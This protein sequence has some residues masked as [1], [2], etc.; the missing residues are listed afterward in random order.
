MC[1]HVLAIAWY[2]GRTNADG[3]Y[4]SQPECKMASAFMVQ[5]IVGNGE[6]TLLATAGHVFTGY[7]KDAKEKG[8]AA[9]G[10]CLF[11]VWGPKAKID[12]PI[13][14][15]IFEENFY[16]EDE[17]TEGRDCGFVILPELYHMNLAQTTTPFPREYWSGAELDAY[18]QF[19][20]LGLPGEKANVTTGSEG[21]RN[22]ITVRPKP[23]LLVLDRCE[24]PSD[25]SGADRDQ[26][27][28]RIVGREDLADIRCMSGG[29]IIGVTSLENGEH[30]YSLV[31]MQSKWLS[32]RRII[33][34]TLMSEIARDIDRYFAD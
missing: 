18:D 13:P 32:D 4:T 22:F 15:N 21:N 26:F 16:F 31:A 19:F 27:V 23:E 14:C 5:P 9:T 6:F 17:D 10:H 8:L 24:P 30:R 11:D 3:K 29:P 34:G 28:A 1:Q 25:L 33:A 20:M 12:R 2:Q 7:H